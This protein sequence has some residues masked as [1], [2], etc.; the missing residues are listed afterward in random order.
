L[1][2]SLGVNISLLFKFHPNL[3][4]SGTNWISNLEDYRIFRSK[5][6]SNL[7]NLY[8][9]RCSSLQILQIHIFGSVKV[10]T[11]LK[12]KFK[13]VWIDLTGL[14]S[15]QGTV[16]L[17]PPI[18]APFP[19]SGRPCCPCG[20]PG[21]RPPAPALSLSLPPVWRFTGPPPSHFPRTVVRHPPSLNTAISPPSSYTTVVGACRL[22]VEWAVLGA[23]LI[24]LEY[25][26]LATG[27]R[28]AARASRCGDRVRSAPPMALAGR[29]LSS[30]GPAGR[31]R[32]LRAGPVLFLHFLFLFSF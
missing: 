6:T 18:S 1:S 28:A 14:N 32:G 17:G 11:S 3:K 25:C 15:N 12:F 13:S 30:T 9:E 4:I 20:V 10:R 16:A 21:H 26:R 23:K 22:A 2:W 31:G 19:L 8:A 27:E 29:P 5:Y 7:K 24:S